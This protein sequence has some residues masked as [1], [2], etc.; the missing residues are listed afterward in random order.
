M[1]INEHFL[2]RY[3][4]FDFLFVSRNVFIFNNMCS[5]QNSM[6]VAIS[7]FSDIVTNFIMCDYFFL[8]MFC[9]NIIEIVISFQGHLFSRLCFFYLFSICFLFEHS[10]PA[11]RIPRADTRLTVYRATQ[12]AFYAKLN[13]KNSLSRF[14]KSL[15]FDLNQNLALVSR[16]ASCVCG[17][18]FE[19]RIG[20]ESWR[21]DPKVGPTMDLSF[22]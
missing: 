22:F 16:I 18:I 20:S 5:R 19:F 6:Q 2:F 17:L 12:V 15:I 9:S 10:S 21:Q 11:L 13:E 7:S 4:I 3:Y 14:L 8:E 1:I